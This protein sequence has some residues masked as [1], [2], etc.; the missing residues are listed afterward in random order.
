[1]LVSQLDLVPGTGLVVTG[2]I[3]SG[4]VE[5]GARLVVKGAGSESLGQTRGKEIS[6]TKGNTR[7]QVLEATAG[8]IVSVCVVG[9]Q[10]RWTDTLVSHEDLATLPAKPIDR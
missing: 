2:K 7:E 6:V 3:H 5:P 4:K 1:M 8:D 9:H 10:P